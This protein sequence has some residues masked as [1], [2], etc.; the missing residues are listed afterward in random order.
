MR[1]ETLKQFCSLKV[2]FPYKA[3]SR[4]G[5]VVTSAA[6]NVIT[7]LLTQIY[8]GSKSLNFILILCGVSINERSVFCGYEEDNNNTET[9]TQKK[10]KKKENDDENHH[11]IS[12]FPEG[13][14]NNTN[15]EN[16]RTPKVVPPVPF[17]RRV[18]L[19]HRGDVWFERVNDLVKTRRPICGNVLSRRR[20][21][22]DDNNARGRGRGGVRGAETEV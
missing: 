1:R 16:E 9:E 6:E 4:R 22:S 11:Q 20:R 19:V 5:F 10:K 2:V 18:S 21:R 12:S 3:L 15:D 7:L 13:E 8:C 14:Y 17:R